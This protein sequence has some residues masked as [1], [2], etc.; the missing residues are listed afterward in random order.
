[1]KKDN[2]IKEL[3]E[4]IP[5]PQ[6]LLPENIANML[7][8]KSQALNNPIKEKKTEGK[9]IILSNKTKKK[10]NISHYRRISV[11][12]AACLVLTLGATLFFKNGSQLGTLIKPSEKVETSKV[13]TASSYSEIYKNI[14]KVYVMDDNEVELEKIISNSDDS[15]NYIEKPQTYI[16]ENKINAGSVIEVEQNDKIENLLDVK[17]DTLRS[18]DNFVYY[19]ANDTVYIVDS[20]N[21]ELS[22]I[23]EQK[24]E[25]LHPKC[26]YLIGNN[27]VII[28]DSV[29]EVGSNSKE[30]KQEETTQSAETTAFE[31]E[32]TSEGDS[33]NTETSVETSS[34]MTEDETSSQENSEETTP[35][36][37]TDETTTNITTSSVVNEI[38]KEKAKITTTVIDVVDITDPYNPNLINSVSQDGKYISSR[39]T[40]G[41]IYVAS[42]H[43]DERNK[44]IKNEDDIENYVPSFTVNGKKSFIEPENI[45]FPSQVNNTNYIIVTG[46]DVS[47]VSPVKS[48]KALFGYKDYA[49]FSSDHIYTFAN[50]YGEK[51]QETTIVRM[52]MEKGDI[53]NSVTT[54][55]TGV[56]KDS[57]SFSEYNGNLRVATSVYNKSNEKFTNGLYILDTDMKVCGKITGFGGDGLFKSVKFDN[58]SA[59][60]IASDKDNSKLVID[61]TQ[62]TKP[63]LSDNI[64]IKVSSLS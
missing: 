57:S 58:S 16:L 22:I 12:V 25:N 52:D 35:S 40:D 43:K 36:S 59:F 63:I 30:T 23:R 32:T 24:S 11:S 44:T 60:F 14:Q 20:S 18:K 33:E 51:S 61:C 17:P 46:L 28:S 9:Q 50:V 55:I 4:E 8:E 1:M 15:G 39:I 29:S 7:K 45:I 2:K 26:I 3:F 19:I 42:D 6:E 21:E 41:H 13:V 54:K 10:N 64:E 62:P 5:I 48:A 34:E 37:Q 49:F 53:S 38:I 47:N 56:V 27:L 31:S